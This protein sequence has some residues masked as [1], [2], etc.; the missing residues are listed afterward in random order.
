MTVAT[1]WPII[2]EPEAESRFSRINVEPEDVE[3]PSEVEAKVVKSRR[4]RRPV[5]TSE[6]A[7]TA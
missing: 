6:V 1:L 4:G 5:I 7:E 3:E 2:P